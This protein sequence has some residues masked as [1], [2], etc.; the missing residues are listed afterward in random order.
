MPSRSAHAPRTAL[1]GVSPGSPA[2][3][4]VT[5]DGEEHY[6]ISAYHRMDPFLM[7]VASDSDLW[8]YVTSGGGLTAGRV[9]PDGAL[10][11]Y[12][13]VDQLHDAHHHTGPITL[14]RLDGDDGSRDLWEPFSDSMRADPAIERNLYKNIVG[15]RLVFEEIHRDLDL[16]FR[17][18]WAACD[19]FGWVRTATLENHGESGVRL[20]VLDGL[21]NV[22]PYGAPLGLYQQSSNL[23]DAYKKSELDTATGLGIFSLTAGITDRAEALEVLKANTVWCSGLKDFRVQLSADVIGEFREGVEGENPAVLNGVRGNYL[24]RSDHVLE[25]GSASEWKLIADVGRDHPQIIGRRRE[26]LGQG[27][28]GD[29]IDSVLRG[30]RENLSRNVASA[31]GMQISG[32]TETSSHHFANVLFNNMR[33]GVPLNGYELP[34]SDFIDFLKNRNPGLAVSRRDLLAEL[35]ESVP[36]TELLA[37]AEASDD[38]DFERLCYEYLPLHFGRRHGD[39]SRPW[40]RFSIH[41]KDENGGRVLHYEGNWRDI[42]QNWEA[43]GSAFPGYLSSFVAKFVNASTVDGFNPYRISR[44]GVDWETASSDDPWSNIGYWGDHQIVYLLK[45]L[46]AL[47]RHQPAK[48]G[49]MLGRE[50]FSYAEVPYLIKPYADILADPSAT[51][52]FD[53]KRALRIDMRVAERGA[54]GRLL[55]GADG[56]VYKA[57]L[58]EKLLVPALSKMSNLIPDAGIWMNTQRPEWNDANNALGG[59]GVSVVTLGYL[60][61]YLLFLAEFLEGQE[62]GRL[63]VSRKIA[64][65]F[66]EVSGILKKERGL[67]AANQLDPT[68][69]KRLLD[70]LGEAFSE[71][72][73]AV[74]SKGYESKTELSLKKV[75][76]FCRRSLEFVEWGI[77]ANRREDGLYHSYNHLKFSEDGQG[78]EVLRLEEMLEGQVS[79]LSSGVPDP[80]EA[81]EML[82]RLFESRLYKPEQRSFILYPEKSLPGFLAKNSVP[83]DRAN[84]VSLVK[85]L[86]AVGDDRLLSVDEDGLCRFHGSFRQS[87]DLAAALDLL[88]QDEAWANAVNQD[89][90][91]VLELFEETFHHRTYTGRSGVMY[92]YEG[93][94]C[95]YWHMVAKLLLAVQEVIHRAEFDGKS[96]ELQDELR[97]MYFRIRSGFGFEK[98]VSEY[99]AFPTD[100]YSHTSPSGRAKQPGMTG[101]VKEAILTRSGELGVRVHKGHLSFEPSLL[102]PN[103]FLGAATKFD[104]FDLAGDRRRIELPPGSLAFTVCQVP[105]IYLGHADQAGIRIDFSDGSSTEQVG[106]GLDAD[107]SAEIFARSGKVARITVAIPRERIHTQ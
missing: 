22:L 98:S 31:D 84:E 95:I 28:L 29:R 96:A 60:R 45:L 6:R 10:F 37:S 14:I 47:D 3:E 23:V 21:R 80:E 73:G 89:R 70:S 8:M 24:V 77:R 82:N 104:Y 91:A 102:S 40:N 106:S 43:L 56:S 13:T 100:P 39:P 34:T 55:T 16:S 92:G 26:I 66:K 61:R 35:P 7:I 42:F 49:E 68:D 59:G 72:R 2:G 85:D 63:P 17:Y 97:S 18:V 46:E 48:L 62:P 75:I 52:E 32:Q 53:S 94:G 33:G 54:D 20:E 69:R 87:D 41:S 19:E 27:D 105:V 81:Q 90:G 9:D 51:I 71:Y 15:S 65:W 64:S 83:V 88:A 44:D 74:Y 36:V 99:G 107:T 1:V 50:I 93:L 67:L 86:L 12:L 25:P 76:R 30:A 79:A 101:H 103:E 58:L 4:F 5:L 38:A 78:V 57:N 11:P